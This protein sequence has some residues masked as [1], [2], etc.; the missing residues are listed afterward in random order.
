MFAMFVLIVL[1]LIGEIIVGVTGLPVPGAVVG[2]VILY[3][4][5]AL[6]GDVPDE[7]S[8]TSN[9]LLHNLGLLFVPAGVGVIAY[10]PMIAS[11]WWIIVLVLLISVSGT[12]VVTGL[13]VTW[14]SPAELE[15]EK[16]GVRP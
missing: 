8:R 1:Q 2:L 9:F 7:I 4:M 3:A 5:L 14:L 6:R 10:L 15:A 16:A 12:I 11:A 13:V